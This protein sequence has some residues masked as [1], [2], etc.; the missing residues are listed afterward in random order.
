MKE[1]IDLL[2]NEKEK[3]ADELVRKFKLRYKLLKKKFFF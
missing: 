2:I 3:L 1:K